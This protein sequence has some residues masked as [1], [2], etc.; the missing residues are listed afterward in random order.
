MIV[1]FMGVRDKEKQGNK[2]I[3]LLKKYWF[4]AVFRRDVVDGRW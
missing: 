2:I 1:P 3:D 4:I